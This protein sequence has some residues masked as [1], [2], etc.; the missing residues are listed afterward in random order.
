MRHQVGELALARDLRGDVNRWQCRHCGQPFV[1][2][3]LLADH[4][5]KHE[6]YGLK[7]ES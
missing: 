3:S 1:V 6:K 5:T 2:P 4:I 7:L